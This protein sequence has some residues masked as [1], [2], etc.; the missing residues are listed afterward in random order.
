MAKE[1]LIIGRRDRIDLPDLGIRNISAK[2][3]TGAYTS[4]LHASHVTVIKGTPDKLSFRIEGH[5]LEGLEFLTE[6]FSERNIKNS[7]GHVERR[8][9]IR[10]SVLIFNQLF[11]TEFSLSDR[12]G[13]KHPILLGRKF[14]RGKFIA[15]V[16]KLNLS[17][18]LKRK[19][20]RK[21]IS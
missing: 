19:K 6:N 16:S 2:V 1:K 21:N 17:Y 18:K 10:T 8:F 14:I 3:D 9:V 5:D 11:E 12:S 13:M 7:F 15:D 4:A 20:E